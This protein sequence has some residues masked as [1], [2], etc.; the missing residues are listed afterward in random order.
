MR[1]HD[2]LYNLICDVC[3]DREY[4]YASFV[5][6]FSALLK[7]IFEQGRFSETGKY[8]VNGMKSDKVAHVKWRLEHQFNL[9]GLN[10][11]TFECEIENTLTGKKEK[12]EKAVF[13]L[14]TGDSIPDISEI[15]NEN[16]SKKTNRKK[17]R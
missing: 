1:L 5:R 16:K 9:M 17:L 11:V 8:D 6:H 15:K 12:L 13:E 14:S 2:W 7:D 10:S 3:Y 4:V